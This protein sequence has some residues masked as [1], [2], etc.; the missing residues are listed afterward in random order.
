[1]IQAIQD[2]QQQA[3]SQVCPRHQYLDKDMHMEMIPQWPKI[4]KRGNLKGQ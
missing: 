3:H 4:L 1:M 2:F